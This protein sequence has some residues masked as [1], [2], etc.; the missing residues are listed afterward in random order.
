MR[1]L[2]H[3]RDELSRKY[4]TLKGRFRVS[5]GEFRS[6]GWFPPCSGGSFA[7]QLQQT[8]LTALL[9]AGVESESDE[10]E[11]GRDRTRA[12]ESEDAPFSF[13]LEVYSP[14]HQQPSATS[15]ITTYKQVQLFIIRGWTC[16]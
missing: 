14:L 15:D 8:V 4:D 16:T 13:E 2:K 11:G 6:R 1:A 7:L 5:A 3:E 12:P 9:W 10:E